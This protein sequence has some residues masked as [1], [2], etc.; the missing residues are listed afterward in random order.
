MEQKLIFEQK[1]GNL[2]LLIIKGSK[3]KLCKQKILQKTADD[4]KVEIVKL[5]EKL[6]A[7]NNPASNSKTKQ[8]RVTT[9]ISAWDCLTILC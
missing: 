1:T 6:L 4:A 7:A 9:R 3:F 5:N 2:N 8:V